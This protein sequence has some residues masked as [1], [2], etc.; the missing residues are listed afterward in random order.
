[1][2]SRATGGD[3]AVTQWIENVS[4][5]R[6]RGPAALARAWVEVLVNPS[7]FFERAIAPGDQAPGLVFAMAVV[8]VEEATRFALVPGVPPTV[9]GQP[10]LSVAF[11]LALVTLFVAPAVLHL[12]AALQTL[13]LLV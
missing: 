4:G 6:E 7:R 5:G 8:L 13:L 1:M 3:P 10:A 12:T 9:D 11:W 2:T